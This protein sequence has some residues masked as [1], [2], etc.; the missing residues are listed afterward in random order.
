MSQARRAAR[1]GRQVPAWL[2]VLI[3]VIVVAAAVFLFMRSQGGSRGP[4]QTPEL[5]RIQ[6]E[7]ME[8]MRRTGGGPRMQ[9]MR[10]GG[11]GGRRGGRAGQRGAPGQPAGVPGQ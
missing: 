8:T 4:T 7:I 9:Q 2:G 10:G 5:K 11:R 6:R 3:I 1:G